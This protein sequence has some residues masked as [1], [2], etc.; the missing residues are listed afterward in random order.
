MED[1][2]HTSA[3]RLSIRDLPEPA[4][5]LHAC[6]GLSTSASGRILSMD[7]SAVASAPGVVSVLT[8]KDITPDEQATLDR[9][10]DRVI[11]KGSVS[12]RDL[13]AELRSV[14]PPADAP[15]ARH[16]DDPHH[17][18]PHYDDEDNQR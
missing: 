7:L 9:G 10:A 17:D 8:A 11:V 16:D 6:L 18:D 14:V 15:A 13:A 2:S 5:L 3:G 4:G 1:S 12:L